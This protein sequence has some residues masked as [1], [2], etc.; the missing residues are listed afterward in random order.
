MTLKELILS[1]NSKI[2][3]EQV[4]ERALKSKDDL[5]LLMDY[6][7]STDIRLVH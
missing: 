6:F 4:A 5:A 3:W 2:V 7:E 1:N